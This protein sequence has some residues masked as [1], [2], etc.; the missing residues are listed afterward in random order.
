MSETLAIR[1]DAATNKKLEALARCS[2]RSTSF[3]AA[4][5]IRVYVDAEAWRLGEIQAGLSDLDEV[6]MVSH[7][8]VAKWLGSWGKRSEHKP[9]R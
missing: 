4:E 5:A 8:R 6:K 7:D 9:P 1:I 3:L 2:K